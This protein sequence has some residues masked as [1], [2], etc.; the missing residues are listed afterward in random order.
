MCRYRQ[1]LQVIL[2]HST[3]TRWRLE[4]ARTWCVTS[5]SSVVDTRLT[6]VS[7]MARFSAAKSAKQIY[8]S[9]LD[10]LFFYRHF[11][12]GTGVGCTSCSNLF[13]SVT[14][15]SFTPLTSVYFF[16]MSVCVGLSLFVFPKSGNSAVFLG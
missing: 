7:G 15:S 16:T 3:M 10:I 11:S 4:L 2:D 13:R 9:I 1:W 14:C 12:H 8:E 6:S 5:C